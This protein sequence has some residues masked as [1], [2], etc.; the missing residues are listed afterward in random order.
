MWTPGDVEDNATGFHS[1]G[2][3]GQNDF[4]GDIRHLMEHVVW[5]S[6]TVSHKGQL[7]KMVTKAT[8]GGKKR[9]VTK[10]A[11]FRNLQA[12]A[13]RCPREQIP[14]GVASFR[15]CNPR[16]SKLIYNH[17]VLLT[18]KTPEFIIYNLQA[19]GRTC[20]KTC[21]ANMGDG[22]TGIFTGLGCGRRKQGD[23]W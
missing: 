2:C 10:V 23:I 6:V 3:I 13:L 19:R 11:L 7:Y 17:I 18:R 9:T 1:G 20:S 4:I 12:L 22:I 8:S 5:A 21:M 14:S 16:R 15:W